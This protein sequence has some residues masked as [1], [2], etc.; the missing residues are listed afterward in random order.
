[1]GRKVHLQRHRCWQI[2]SDD[3][4]ALSRPTAEAKASHPPSVHDAS[5]VKEEDHLKDG[6]HAT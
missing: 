3:R 4:P 1:M 6:K 2:P 5:Q